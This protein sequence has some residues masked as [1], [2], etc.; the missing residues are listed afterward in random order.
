MALKKKFRKMFCII[1]SH[2]NNVIVTYLL[3]TRP[4]Y[5]VSACLKASLQAPPP[6]GH[7]KQSQGLFNLAFPTRKRSSLPP[8]TADHRIKHLSRKSVFVHP[9]DMAE[10]AEPL[11]I[12]TLNPCQWRAH[13]A[14]SWFGYGSHRQL[15]HTYL[16]QHPY[17]EL[18]LAIVECVKQNRFRRIY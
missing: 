12:N 1:F 13:T 2:I 5:R 3:M 16:A 14:P 7:T 9:K 17:I 8:M 18:G 10:A 4:Y 6:V 11:A 15:L